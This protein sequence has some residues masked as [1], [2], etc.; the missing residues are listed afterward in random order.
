MPPSPTTRRHL[1]TK[2]HLHAARPSAAVLRSETA[3]P[4][5]RRLNQSG[6]SARDAAVTRWVISRAVARASSGRAAWSETSRTRRIPSTGLLRGEAAQRNRCKALRVR[7]TGPVRGSSPPP[8][9][10]LLPPSGVRRPSAA[11][12]HICPRRSSRVPPWCASWLMPGSRERV[13]SS[14]PAW[15]CAGRRWNDASW[16]AQLLSSAIRCPQGRGVRTR[17]SHQGYN[18]R[19]PDP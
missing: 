13:D 4:P 6:S 7:G 10:P 1:I 19:T 9:R 8:P 12:P 16:T 11:C 5:P 2:H 3:P 18:A 15:L 14:H 17:S